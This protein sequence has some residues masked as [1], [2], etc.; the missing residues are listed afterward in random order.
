MERELGGAMESGPGG[1]PRRTFLTVTGNRNDTII[2]EN[3]PISKVEGRIIRL[4]E[5]ASI[6][7]KEQK[8]TRFFRINGLNTINLTVSAERNVNHIKVAAAVR[9]EADVIAGELP[10]GYSMRKSFDTTT[11]IKKEINK[12]IN[13]TIF[14]VV[15][16]LLFVFLIS[17]QFRYLLVIAISLLANLSI[18]F[19]FYYLFKLELHLYSLAGITVSFGI[20]IDNTIVMTDHLRHQ[21]NRKVFLA[22]LAATLTTIGALS[23]IFFMGET[24]KV[25]L[26]DFAAVIIIN[27]VVSLAV[28]LLF[29][30]S[31]ID[32]IKLP[33]KFN[34]A[35]IRRKRR[36][37][38]L[39]STYSSFIKF[40]RRFRWA[41]ILLIILGFGVPVYLLP[42]KLP[43]K[44]TYGIQQPPVTDF[45][46]FYNKTIGNNKFNQ[47]VRPVINKALGGSM[48]LFYEKVKSG[49]SYFR[50]SDEPPRTMVNVRI[51]RSQEWKQTYYG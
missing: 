48:R 34:S 21:G 29:I 40:G 9:A 8:A 32:K 10:Q 13:R 5:I 26:S 42:A 39:R 41:F 47:K 50:T 49:I 44:T 15:L 19:I 20:I 25:M 45:Q 46:K 23:V 2:W 28:A 51:G 12:I 6:R 35:V 3:I 7:L 38:R 17:R 33:V 11:D 36:V 18:A 22:I 27:L 24:T 1:T 14:S 16:L 30:P 43:A 37:V 4:G 31:L